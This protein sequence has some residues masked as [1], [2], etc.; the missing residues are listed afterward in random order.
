MKIA[1]LSVGMLAAVLVSG[2]FAPVFAQSGATKEQAEE[3]LK[4]AAPDVKNAELS[5][6]HNAQMKQAMKAGKAAF[7]K[8]DYDK[9]IEKFNAADAMTKNSPNTQ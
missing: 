6:E 8:G 2:V 1:K 4:K 7:A 3:A 5:S 9:A